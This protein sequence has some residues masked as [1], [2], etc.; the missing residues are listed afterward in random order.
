MTAHWGSEGGE[1]TIY[2]FSKNKTSHF[3]E[4]G[5]NLKKKPNQNQQ[6]CV[7]NHTIQDLIVQLL[8]E[9]SCLKKD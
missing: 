1:Y 4:N 8:C 2:L 9:S 6:L 7:Q 3:H 5:L